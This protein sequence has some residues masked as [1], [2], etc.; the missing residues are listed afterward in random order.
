MVY[1]S[2]QFRALGYHGIVLRCTYRVVPGTFFFF[3]RD[4]LFVACF[5]TMR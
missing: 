3:P 2:P 5:V 1:Y 4:A